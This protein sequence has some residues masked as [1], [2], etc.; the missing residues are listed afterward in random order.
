MPWLMAVRGRVVACDREQDEERGDLVTSQRLLVILG[1][2]E[3]RDEIVGR[4]AAP[5]LGE[6]VDERRGAAYP[7]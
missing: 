4:L 1:I 5:Q 2:H 7:R 3:R 6:L